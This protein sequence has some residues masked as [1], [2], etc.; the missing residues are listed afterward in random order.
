MLRTTYQLGSVSQR[1]ASGT[2]SAP[3]ADRRSKTRRRRTRTFS[4]TSTWSRLRIAPGPRRRT[5]RTAAGPGVAPREAASAD[6]VSGP[7]RCSIW[8]CIAARVA[9][10]TVSSA[11]RRAMPSMAKAASSRDPRASAPWTS[12]SSLERTSA[13]LSS[14]WRP[15]SSRSV[16]VSCRPTASSVSVATRSPRRLERAEHDGRPG[17]PGE[18]GPR[19]KRQVVLRVVPVDVL[20]AKQREE[21]PAENLEI[22][23]RMRLVL[24]R[25]RARGGQ[26]LH[27]ALGVARERHALGAQL[28]QHAEHGVG[29]HGGGEGLERILA[30][31]VGG[32]DAQR[33]AHEALPEGLREPHDQLRGLARRE[34]AAGPGHPLEVRGRRVGQPGEEPGG[35]HPGG[36]V[37]SVGRA[38]I[39][40]NAGPRA[41]P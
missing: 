21:L 22:A 18:H 36:R 17:R 34:R 3:S 40:R 7:V 16:S 11:A 30:L 26:E 35:R 32:H 33:G 13:V 15:R 10:G 38:L 2:T 12:W 39:R 20:V 25:A 24:V 29:A 41:Q 9:S 1:V 27:Q 14:T 6:S 31:G 8:R 37:A 23:G 4:S 5:S 28:T 19:E